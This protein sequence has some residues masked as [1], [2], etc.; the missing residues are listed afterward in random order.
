MLKHCMGSSF[1]TWCCMRFYG[2][3]FL[4]ALGKAIGW[5]CLGEW[6][7]GGWN[8]IQDIESLVKSHPCCL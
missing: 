2:T 3:P 7:G 1:V 5:R 4:L 6:F 8:T